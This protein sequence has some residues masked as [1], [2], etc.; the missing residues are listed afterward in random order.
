MKFLIKNA[1]LILIMLHFSPILH[2][3][4]NPRVIQWAQQTLINTLS[5]DYNT[6]PDDFA[7]ISKHY[8]YNAWQGITQFLGGY[9]KTIKENQLDLHPVLQGDA[10]ISSTGIFSGIS[11][12]VIEQSVA[13]K[14]LDI[15]L[16]FTLT[17]LARN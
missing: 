9:M 7:N 2:A 5:V 12:W 17:I 3:D 14:E 13:I 10:Q 1:I 6:K 11:Y 16:S 15:T 8:S 4:E